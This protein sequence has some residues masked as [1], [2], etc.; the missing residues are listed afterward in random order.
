MPRVVIGRHP[1]AAG[2]GIYIA[3]PGQDVAAYNPT[4]RDGLSLSSDWP[5]VACVVGSGLCAL[6]A[7]VPYPSVVSGFLP[8]VQFNRLLSTGYDT[9]ETA[10]FLTQ[11]YRGGPFTVQEEH[12][13]RW[14]CSQGSSGFTI[15]RSPGG[16]TDSGAADAVFR[17]VLFNMSVLG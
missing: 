16:Y 6:G 5:Q 3:L 11:I 14:L 9:H 13:S 1:V 17:Y 4:A 10:V 15:V 8:Y 2:T 7:F 12:R